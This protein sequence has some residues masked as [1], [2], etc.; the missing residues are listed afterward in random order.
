MSELEKMQEKLAQ[1][2][3]NNKSNEFIMNKL[4]SYIENLEKSLIETHKAHILRNARNEELLKEQMIFIEKFLNNNTYFYLSYEEKYFYYDN[5]EFYLH[6]VNDVIVRI[7]SYLVK[8]NNENLINMKL[9]IQNKII[10]EIKNKSILNA[11]PNSCTIQNTLKSFYNNAFKCKDHAKYFLITLGDC[12]LK[13]TMNNYYTSYSNKVF[14][15]EISKYVNKYLNIYEVLG[16]IKYK[17]KYNDNNRFLHI[18]ISQCDYSEIKQNFIKIIIV[19]CYYSNRYKNS[20]N[21]LNT[22][23][24]IKVKNEILLLS[25]NE[26]Y[27]VRKFFDE[28]EIKHIENIDK[29]SS[30]SLFFLW[31][32]FINYYKFPYMLN[33]KQVYSKIIDLYNF[34]N[35]N[36]FENNNS[37]THTL[38]S[39]GNKI[40]HEVSCFVEFMKWNCCNSNDNEQFEIDELVRIYKD[41]DGCVDNIN[42]ETAMN[43]IMYY[44]PNIRV[45]ENKYIIVNNKYW[46]KLNEVKSFIQIYKKSNV[47]R[48]VYDA[49]EKYT[50]NELY[51]YIANK[52]YFEYVYE[53]I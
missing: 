23:C 7:H 52:S 19:A 35:V 43:A 31:E 21:F 11:I 24:D 48:N 36:T 5:I 4:T 39:I 3:E 46:N 17:Y 34:L 40:M 44:L 6:D 32:T 2:Y 12:I 10:K 16:I 53:D 47:Y 33:E 30:N 26:E 49:Y 8:E 41:N 15:D 42:D 22:Y 27:F 37:L 28:M 45:Y 29:V 18:N 51:K 25:E 38:S 14:I 50:S 1:I 9:N 13:K 20:E